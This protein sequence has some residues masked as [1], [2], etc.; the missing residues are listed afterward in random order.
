MNNLEEAK[1]W[2]I[3]TAEWTKTSNDQYECARLHE[4]AGDMDTA[5]LWYQKA[6]EN[7]SARAKLKISDM[8]N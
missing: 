7:G 4:E 8:N 2:A 3:A 6:A 1:S 5:A